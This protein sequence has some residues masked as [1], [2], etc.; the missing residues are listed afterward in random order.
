M[1]KLPQDSKFIEHETYCLAQGFA[2]SPILSAIY[3]V[4][5]IAELIKLV[6]YIDPKGVVTVYAD[7]IQISLTEQSY[8]V[9][10]RLITYATF[11]FKKYKHQENTYTR[12]I[13]ASKQSNAIISTE[14]M[15][16]SRIFIPGCN[17]VTGKQIGRAHV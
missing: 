9:L 5:P 15:L 17:I 4:N 11:I 8:D 2:T 12:N 3:L 6:R 14:Q 10:N 7:D 13:L 1:L 16:D